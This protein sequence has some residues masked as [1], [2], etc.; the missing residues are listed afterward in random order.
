MKT[1]AQAKTSGIVLRTTKYGESGIIATLLTRDFGRVS[2]IA[3][4]VRS[5]NSKLRAGL[6]LF[7]YSEIVMY[8]AKHKNGLYHLDEME[9]LESFPALRSDLLKM[10]YATYFA[11]VVKD[12]ANDDSPDEDVLSLMLNT[13]FAID[14]GLC[15]FEKIKTVFEWRLAMI[16]GYA[17]NLC[18]CAKCGNDQICSLSLAEGTSLCE[19][20]AKDVHGIAS[21]SSTMQ[22][23][24]GYIVSAEN[25]KIFSF[26]AN[27]SIIEYLSRVSERYL[28]LQ[29][30]REF[31]TLEY[32]KKVRQLDN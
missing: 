14:R 32:L 9:I 17:P 6:Q 27:Q 23:I 11:E 2:A 15:G 4:G 13:L 26:D 28:S 22:A 1:L 19:L 31:K 8:K 25:K 21:L 30:D 29:L 20:C 12:S 16:L 10:A 24:I 3:Q 18:G 5:K 7:S